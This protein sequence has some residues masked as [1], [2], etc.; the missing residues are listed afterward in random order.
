[1]LA[2]LTAMVADTMIVAIEGTTKVGCNDANPLHLLT[3][4]VQV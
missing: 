4:I 3:P 1:M 2:T